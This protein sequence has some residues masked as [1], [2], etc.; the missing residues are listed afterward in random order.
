MFYKAKLSQKPSRP[1][2]RINLGAIKYM[3]IPL[4]FSVLII[5][6]NVTHCIWLSSLFYERLVLRGV[7]FGS[8]SPSTFIEVRVEKFDKLMYVVKEQFVF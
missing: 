1:G 8:H 7:M 2:A 3:V 4:R 5:F 6:L